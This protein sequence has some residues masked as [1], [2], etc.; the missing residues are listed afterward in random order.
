M[1]A[2]FALVASSSG[3]SAF[4]NK[5]PET[6]GPPPI[7]LAGP[8]PVTIS[9]PGGKTSGAP[10]PIA[11]LRLGSPVNR[12]STSFTTGGSGT[13]NYAVMARRKQAGLPY[14]PMTFDSSSSAL[15]VVYAAQPSEIAR[16]YL[17]QKLPLK[18]MSDAYDPQALVFVQ[19]VSG[20]RG[21][22][23]SLS[24]TMH[25]APFARP[26]VRVVSGVSISGACL[27]QTLDVYAPAMTAAQVRGLF[28]TSG[29]NW[30]QLSACQS[31][32]WP[33]GRVLFLLRDEKA[34]RNTYRWV[35]YDLLAKA[36][37]PL[38]E[39]SEATGAGRGKSNG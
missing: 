26:R 8:C 13:A 27:Q 28:S 10:I 9:E 23:V 12:A 20:A 18:P 4:Y 24:L 7:A 15:P 14:E 3:S 29:C 2:G 1:V 17:Y 31:S 38:W 11:A 22:I 35:D 25:K 6:V 30:R 19:P 21:R 39:T 33:R 34:T 36:K 5:P 16:G 32:Q 37:T